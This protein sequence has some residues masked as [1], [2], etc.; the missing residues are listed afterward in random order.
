MAP[1]TKFLTVPARPA[2][3]SEVAAPR[4]IFAEL[5]TIALGN[6]YGKTP[7]P[8]TLYDRAMLKPVMTGVDDGEVSKLV[9]RF[10]DWVRLEGL[11]RAAE[12]QKSY[13]LNRETLS[14]LSTATPVGLLGE[15]MERFARCYANQQAS[16]ELRRLARALGSYFLSRG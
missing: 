7:I 12:G 1:R 13:M 4:E 14:V 9:G 8:G 11:V 5:L 3:A 16:P 2:E 15:V 10:E 6:L